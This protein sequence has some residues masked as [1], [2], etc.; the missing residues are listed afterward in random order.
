M[1]A[2][3]FVDTNVL[4]YA[5]D[6]SE[7]RKQKRAMVWMSHLWDMR[8]GRLS[9]QVLQEFYITVTDK[10][11]PG[12]DPQTARR[13]VRLLLSWK[14][15]SVDSRVME[16]AWHLQDRHRLSWWDALILSA[17]R[18]S[19]CP[20]LLTEDLGEDQRFGDLQVINPFHVSP[21]TL[22]A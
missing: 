6:A 16:D 19:Q 7:P 9:F 21:E 2:R 11:T 10:L 15:V 4:V 20:Y 14:P 17:A 1:P 5:R 18:A 3:V 8:L 13:D 12:L 22:L